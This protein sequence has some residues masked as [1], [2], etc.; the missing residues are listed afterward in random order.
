[1]QEM[2]EC[3]RCMN[4]EDAL[5]GQILGERISPYGMK[6]RRCRRC[7]SYTVFCCFH[8]S[9]RIIHFLHCISPVLMR[10]MHI[11]QLSS[12]LSVNLLYIL[13]CLMCMRPHACMSRQENSPVQECRRFRTEFI[14]LFQTLAKIPSKSRYF[15][16]L[17]LH[18]LSAA[19]WGS[20]LS[21]RAGKNLINV[22]PP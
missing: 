12:Q 19:S 20:Q 10:I 22:S 15:G 7:T 16:Y 6:C 17:S 8:A 4:V 21:I 11:R 2:Q 9:L 3:R 14:T 5:Q 1:M 13:R 18:T